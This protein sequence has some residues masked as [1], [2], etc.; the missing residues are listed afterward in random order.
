VESRS[1]KLTPH[2]NAG[3]FSSF[4]QIHVGRKIISSKHIDSIRI[5]AILQTVDISP[6]PNILSVDPDIFRIL[7]H[8]RDGYD[9]HSHLRLNSFYPRCLSISTS[10]FRKLECIPARRSTISRTGRQAKH[11]YHFNWRSSDTIPYPTLFL[12]IRKDGNND[13]KIIHYSQ[14]NPT[15]LQLS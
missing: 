4:H 15:I 6:S 13:Q 11:N 14:P 2:S 9:G 7:S 1:L 12:K 8:L 5:P 3:K 10:I